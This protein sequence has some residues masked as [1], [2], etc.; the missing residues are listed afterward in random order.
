MG[1]WLATYE[2]EMGDAEEWLM[3]GVWGETDVYGVSGVTGGAE[4]MLEGLEWGYEVGTTVEG[5]SPCGEWL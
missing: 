1:G 5:E 4:P 2:G 3:Y